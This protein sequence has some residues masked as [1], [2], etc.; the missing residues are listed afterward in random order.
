MFQIRLNNRM[1]IVTILFG[2]LYVLFISCGKNDINDPD[3]IPNPV[4][5][6]REV[7]EFKFNETTGTITSETCL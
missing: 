3:P 5:E 6:L 1:N 2:L 7:F 4:N